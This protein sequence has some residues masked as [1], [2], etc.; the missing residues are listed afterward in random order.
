MLFLLSIL[1]VLLQMTSWQGPN[2]Q[3]TSKG[4]HV[5]LK[6]RRQHMILKLPTGLRVTPLEPIQRQPLRISP[7]M[8]EL[9]WRSRSHREGG[10]IDGFS[11]RVSEKRVRQG[12]TGPDVSR[13]RWLAVLSCDLFPLGLQ[14][15]SKHNQESACP[16]LYGSIIDVW[17]RAWTV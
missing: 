2:E 5:S 7:V 6:A 10:W 3:S 1:L 8:K 12:H 16:C 4:T 14:A 11:R 9:G 15:P 17:L 13:V